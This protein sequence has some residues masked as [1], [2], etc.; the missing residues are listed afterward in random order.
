M[1]QK[2]MIGK[3]AKPN[4]LKAIVGV[5][6]DTTQHWNAYPDFIPRLGEV[7]AYLDRFIITD[8][9]TG[10]RTLV[11]DIKIGDGVHRLIDLPFAGDRG[12]EEITRSEIL[13]IFQSTNVTANANNPVNPNYTP[14]G[15]INR[16]NINLSYSVQGGTAAS[17]TMPSLDMSVENETLNIVWTDG[18]FTPNIPTNIGNINAELS[19]APTFTGKPT[20][21]TV[22]YTGV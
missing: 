17:C 12:S 22:N 7:I 11:P 18:S 3:M 8:A 14:E 10:H 6:R 21:I 20:E 13:Q 19:D 1:L 16:P 5:S 4:V 2:G 15:T 9:N